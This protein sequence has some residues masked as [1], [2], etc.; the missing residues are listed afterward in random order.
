MPS[1]TL[2]HTYECAWRYTHINGLCTRAVL[3]RL[4]VMA[5]VSENSV[6]GYPLTLSLVEGIQFVRV[7][8]WFPTP[9]VEVVL[10][11]KLFQEVVPF[12]LWDLKQKEIHSSHKPHCKQLAGVE[13][14]LETA[15]TAASNCGI[16]AVS[17]CSAFLLDMKWGLH[18]HKHNNWWQH[19]GKSPSS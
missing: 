1:H 10:L 5:C 11:F 2:K 15:R 19:F 14:T 18:C 16:C 3:C 6:A 7:L 17:W 4:P 9:G 13:F 8:A 12:C